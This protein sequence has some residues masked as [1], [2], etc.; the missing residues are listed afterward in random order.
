M[1]AAASLE[2]FHAFMLVHDDLID[3]STLRRGRPT[4]HEAFRLGL[5][6][7]EG[8]AAT[9]RA[10]DLGLLA[11]DLLMALGMRMLNRSG[12]DDATLGRANRLVAEMLVETGVGEALDLL[13]DACPLDRLDE[14]PLIEAYLHKTARYTV[15][16]PLVLGATI[17]GAGPHVCEALGR[18]GDLLG[19]GYQVRNDLAAL[20][21]DP[22]RGDHADLDG[23]K[24][25]FVLWM[26]YRSL[27][28]GGREALVDALAAPASLERRY[29]LLAL[30][31]ESGAVAAC[32]DRL[33]AVERE[34]V[35]VLETAKLGAS[36]R[37]AFLGLVELFRPSS[38]RAAST[39]AVEI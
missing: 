12:L 30:I 19:F 29:R 18:F 17:A 34:A 26:A 36:R 5:D 31:R 27:D 6:D 16:G 25:T 20:G 3:A 14:A 28:A 8:H 24:R 33:V 32:R 2:L 11:G 9:K 21:E 15:S 23:G 37:R 22:A 35:A 7:A 4:L 39:A 10:G 38:R 13:G 1:A